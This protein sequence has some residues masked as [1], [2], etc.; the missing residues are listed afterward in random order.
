MLRPKTIAIISGCV[1]FAG[2]AAI[3]YPE[4]KRRKSNQ[5]KA[6]IEQLL[7]SREKKD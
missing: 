1:L 2:M 6:E 4:M 7:R 3:S 5:V